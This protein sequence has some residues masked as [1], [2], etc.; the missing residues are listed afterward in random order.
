MAKKFRTKRQSLGIVQPTTSS[1][2]GV[3][4]S[5]LP[6]ARYVWYITLYLSFSEP[7]CAHLQ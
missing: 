3:Y 5:C 4:D 1:K 2:L 7:Q 6:L